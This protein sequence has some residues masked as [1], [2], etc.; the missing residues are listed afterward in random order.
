MEKN[1]VPDPVFIRPYLMVHMKLHFIQREIFRKKRNNKNRHFRWL[2]SV[3]RDTQSDTQTPWLNF[4][5]VKII[6]YVFARP[7]KQD[8]LTLGEVLYCAS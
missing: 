5:E 6:L 7:I 2:S 3:S 4:C 1:A 8:S